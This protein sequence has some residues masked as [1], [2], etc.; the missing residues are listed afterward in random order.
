MR[1]KV[2]IVLVIMLVFS[3]SLLAGGCANMES[4]T[5]AATSKYP[6][7]PITI[8]VPFSAGSGTDLTARLLEKIAPKYLGQA[9]VVVNRPGAT[10]S[11]G[12]N[13]L[14]NASPNGYTIGV[15]AFDLLLLP[16]YG[17]NKYDYPTALNPLVQVSAVPMVLVA[18]S[19]L[20]CQTLDELINYGKKNP[21]KLKFGG[22]GVGGIPHV[23]GG[24][25]NQE[26][27]I[28]A[29]Y[30]PFN[31]SSEA[32]AALLGGHLQFIF[33]N[34]MTI[35]EHIRNGTVKALAVTGEQRLN[36]PVLSEIPTFKEQGFNITLKNWFGIASPKELPDDVQKTLTEGLKAMIK[37][38][39]FQKGMLNMGLPVEYLGPEE[40]RE[41]WIHDRDILNKELKKT[42]ILE[43]IKSQKNRHDLKSLVQKK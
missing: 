32:T 37:D 12:W 4:K 9:L 31:G 7:Q 29:E 5:V 26:A 40:T 13:E 3:I 35:K 22:G 20:Q 8:I 43:Q 1:N 14:I 19:D 18:H 24:M 36:D 42:G 16:H 41:K 30:V 6:N 33:V 38:P 25:F 39:E 23:L 21:E 28:Q 27:G 15:T 11:I 2:M 10:G 17:I 34:P